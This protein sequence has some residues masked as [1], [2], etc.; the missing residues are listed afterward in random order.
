MYA[1][2]IFLYTVEITTEDRTMQYFVDKVEFEDD[3]MNLYVDI[4]F[5]GNTFKYCLKRIENIS[6]LLGFSIRLNRDSL[7]TK[8]PVLMNEY[9]TVKKI[10]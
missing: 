2:Y 7:S 3:A 5:N 8:R 9:E 6:K 1:D 10:T 4:M